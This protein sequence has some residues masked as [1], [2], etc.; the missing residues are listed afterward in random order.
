MWQSQHTVFNRLNGD[1]K[2]ALQKFCRRGMV[3]ESIA[4]CLEFLKAITVKLHFKG[5][6]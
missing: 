2:S 3:N 6:L 5:C 4:C 1:V